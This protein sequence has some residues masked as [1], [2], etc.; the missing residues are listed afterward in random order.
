MTSLPVGKISWL[1]HCTV[2][3]KLGNDVCSA[4]VGLHAFTGCD[5]TSAFVG[6]SKKTAFDLVTRQPPFAAT[7]VQLGQEFQP[8]A[9]LQDAYEEFT[10]SLYGK[11]GTS[12]NEVSQIC[13]GFDM[14]SCTAAA[15]ATT[16]THFFWNLAVI[17]TEI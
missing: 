12:V 9:Q 16:I 7:M 15:M 8:S 11:P 10:C 1:E 5:S 13:L 4:L 14:P 6:E 2:S 17:A 3:S